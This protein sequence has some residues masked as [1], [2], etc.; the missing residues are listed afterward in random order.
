MAPPGK[1]QFD[2]SDPHERERLRAEAEAVKREQ[3][4]RVRREAET[5]KRQHAQIVQAELS[6]L[7]LEMPRL[8]RDVEGL[9]S[10]IALSEGKERDAREVV[11]KRGVRKTQRVRG[12]GTHSG[13]ATKFE[14]ELKTVKEKEHALSVHK[15]QLEAQQREGESAVKTHTAV[16]TR[17]QSKTLAA[18]QAREKAEAEVKKDEELIA[19][20]TRTLAATKEALRDAQLKEKKLAREEAE[21]TGALSEGQTK[22]T[23]TAA[24]VA[25]R[26]EELK[27]ISEELPKLQAQERELEKKLAEAKTAQETDAETEKQEAR[28]TVSAEHVMRTEKTKITDEK[29]RLEKK[30]EELTAKE[31][32]AKEIEEELRTLGRAA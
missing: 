29:R 12:K 6:R 23:E 7:K 32:R 24:V 30:Q 21:A 4:E 14:T 17:M 15:Q 25:A 8:K 28:E 26:A 9:Q 22:K 2:T 5:K 3:E 13:E 16:S 19:E 10:S 20:L 31:T 1:N 11:E 18:H 27:K